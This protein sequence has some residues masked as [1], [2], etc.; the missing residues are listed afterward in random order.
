MGGL[1]IGLGADWPLSLA[2]TEA[3]PGLQLPDLKKLLW[4]GGCASRRA[5]QHVPMEKPL[6]VILGAG[7]LVIAGCQGGKIAQAPNCPEAPPNWD[8]HSASRPWLVAVSHVDMDLEL[9]FEARRLH[10]TAVYSLRRTDP[11]APL[12]LD[13]AALDGISVW[14]PEGQPREF[15]LSA[16]QERIGQALVIELQAADQAV[17]VSWSTRPEGEALQWLGPEQTA[18]ALQPFMY[19]QGQA[20]LTRSWLPIQDT[21]GNRVSWSAEVSAPRELRVVMSGEGTGAQE[22]PG[23]PGRLLWQHELSLPVPPY[24][25]AL[26]CGRLERRA[27][28]PRVAIFAEPVTIDLAA[29]ELAD[30]D[31]MLATAEQLFGPYRWGRYDVLVLPPAFPYGGME[32]P[33]LTFVNPT[34]LAGDRSLISLI[35]HELAHSWSGNLV[36]NETWEDFWLNEGFTVYCEQRIIEALYGVPRSNMEK[37]LARTELLAEMET[38]EPWQTVLAI[39]LEGH[40]PDMG[41]SWVPYEKGALLLRRIEELVGREDVDD[42]LRGWFEGRA[43]RSASTADFEEYLL[44]GLAELRPGAMANLDLELWLR[45]PGLPDD[46]PQAVSEP[47]LMVDAAVSRLI[48][49]TDPGE[50]ETADWNTFQW[51]RMIHGLGQDA[52]PEL[53]ESLDLSFGLTSTGNAEVLCAWLE[54]GTLGGYEGVQQRLEEFLLTVGRRKYLVPLYTA[55]CASPEGRTRARRIYAQARPLYHAVSTATLDPLIHD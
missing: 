35:A 10:G 25:I 36:T 24:L 9:D 17:T 8:Q 47:L 4:L 54:L 31:A 16:P 19:S 51:L 28:S 27:I 44:H 42:F 1:G 48:A 40:H 18:S 3:A 34:I 20:I 14:G 21:P 33:L 2:P 39:D 5:P 55:L 13:V 53:L 12:I 46:A 29:D 30:L 45:G 22:I 32:N 49:G 11:G 6:R 23:Q 7:L 38:L 26:A 50:I 41:F 52:G 43:F 15:S 37:A